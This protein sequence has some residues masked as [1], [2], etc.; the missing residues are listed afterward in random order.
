MLENVSWWNI[1]TPWNTPKLKSSL[2][3]LRLFVQRQMKQFLIFFQLSC[4]FIDPRIA[5]RKSE[6]LGELESED[7]EPEDVAE[8]AVLEGGEGITLHLGQELLLRKAFVKSGLFNWRDSRPHNQQHWKVWF[9]FLSTSNKCVSSILV[10]LCINKNSQKIII[11]IETVKESDGSTVL[12]SKVGLKTLYLK[13]EIFERV[14]E[15][16]YSTILSSKVG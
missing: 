9:F 1:E 12:F 4:L 14:Q 10:T 5:K 2:I 6:V 11:I 3:F 13:N 8:I 15:S 7:F 16:D